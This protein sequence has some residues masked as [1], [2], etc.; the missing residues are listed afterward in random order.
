MR[1]LITGGTG[2]FG[3]AFLRRA[4][5]P[6]VPRRVIIYS[7]GEAL[8]EQMAR[9]FGIGAHSPVRFMIG[10][11]RDRDRLRM[12]MREVDVV[13][14][15]AA[16]KVVEKCEYDPIE[17]IHTNVYG[18][19][20]VIC[21]AIENNIDK[22]IAISSDKAVA[23][24]NCYGATKLAADKLFIAANNLS[25]S[26]GKPERTKFS[27]CRYGNVANSRGSVI[28]LF[29]AQRLAG[30]PLTITDPGM[31][32]FYITLERAADFVM[33][34]FLTM[35][36]GEIFIP[37]MPSFRIG[38]L[39]DAIEPQPHQMTGIRPG[40]K[41]HEDMILAH[42]ARATIQNEHAYVTL[43]TWLSHCVDEQQRVPAGFHYASD[44]NDQW[45]S[46]DQLAEIAK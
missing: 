38:D 8:Q 31:T 6:G 14:H 36:G 15:A 42:E 25:G 9:E 23:P 29:K 18:A 46:A 16:M 24:I 30:T 21:A 7:R 32:R 19:E 26:P 37:K 34:A 2:S 20:N 27:V 1:I 17:A 4:L 3:R 44:K 40:E 39:A 13:V 5:P 41:M 22:V 33:D 45:L 43:P 12:A 28:P 11:V 35:S 10:D